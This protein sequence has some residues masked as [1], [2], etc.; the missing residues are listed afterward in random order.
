MSTEQVLGDALNDVRMIDQ[1]RP[2]YLNGVADAWDKI[3]SGLESHKLLVSRVLNRVG[4]D[5]VSQRIKVSNYSSEV[6]AGM[7]A[8]A[9]GTAEV[10]NALRAAV[11]KLQSVKSALNTALATLVLPGIDVL[12]IV[13][14]INEYHSTMAALGGALGR[15]QEKFRALAELNSAGGIIP[16]PLELPPTPN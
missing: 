3:G 11:P 12:T 2:E 9:A 16:A 1:S 13:N 10:A 4:D 6:V 14:L 5:W 8:L 7:D 15:A